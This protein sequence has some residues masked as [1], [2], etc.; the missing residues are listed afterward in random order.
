MLTI[1][2]AVSKTFPGTK[3]GV[4][5]ITSV[6]ASSPLAPSEVTEAMNEIQRRYGQLD[7][8]SLK[9]KHPIDSYVAYYK[10]FGYSYHVLAQLES[11]LQGKKQVRAGSGLLQAM[12][13]SELESMLLTAGH[14]LGKLRM[15]I[16]LQV[17]SG[18]ET[19]Q[20]IS[21]KETTAI[22]GD[23]MVCD[24]SGVLSSIMRGPDFDS[25]I[26]ASTTAVLIT[27]YAPPGVQTAE[28]ET[29]LRKL[30]GIIR[31]FSPL[32]KATHL[33]V[34]ESTV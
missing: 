9:D 14:D 29:N 13:L 25:R 10:K 22:R 34:Y 1:D 32:A 30:E 31:S 8:A 17:A 16:S 33:S 6:E 7:R 20:S 28:I 24:G 2:N 18:N 15:P 27:I 3:M 21:G 26:T 4:L 23:L 5:A 19:Y 11:V 12:F